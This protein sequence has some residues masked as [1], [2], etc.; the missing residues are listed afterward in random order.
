MHGQRNV[1]PLQVLWNNEIN[2]CGISG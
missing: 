2:L 1:K